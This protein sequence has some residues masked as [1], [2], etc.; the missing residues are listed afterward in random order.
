MN[1][2]HYAN[3]I[4]LYSCSKYI[5]PEKRKVQRIA[6]YKLQTGT[7]YNEMH[8]QVAVIIFR[9][10][11][12]PDIVMVDKS[13]KSAVSIDITIPNKRRVLGRRNNKY[14]G[15]KNNM[16]KMKVKAVPLISVALTMASKPEK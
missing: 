5:Y 4:W 6:G 1:I 7:A 2:K 15:R 3:I 13:Q 16:R 11:C 9:Y 8:N 14:H 12:I 10:I